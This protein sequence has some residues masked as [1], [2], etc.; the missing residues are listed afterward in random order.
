MNQLAPKIGA[1]FTV[2]VQFSVFLGNRASELQGSPSF[3]LNVSQGP[4]TKNK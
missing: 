4:Q 3:I 1:N 2:F